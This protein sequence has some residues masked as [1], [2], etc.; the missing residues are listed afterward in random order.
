MNNYKKTAVIVGV[1]YILGTLAGILSVI[2][3]GSLLDGPDFLNKI[4]ASQNQFKLAALCVLAMGFVLAVVPVMLYPILKKYNQR[5]ALGY[6][7]FRGALET[8][9]SILLVITWLFLGNLS[10]QSVAGGAL[11]A[12]FFQPLG[13]LLLKGADSISSVSGLIFC[14]GALILY[15]VFYQSKLVPRWLSVWG[16]LAILLNL[17]TSILVI[18]NLQ[19]PFSPINYVMNFPIFLQEMVMAVWLIVKGFNPSKFS[20]IN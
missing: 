1:L 6:V 14:L 18:F 2:F 15:Y 12:S 3:S 4:A 5:L 8:F 20:V 9:G 17:T 16:I 7:V 13:D 11:N 19:S 10:L